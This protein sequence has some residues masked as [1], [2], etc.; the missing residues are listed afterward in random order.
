M[1]LRRGKGKRRE[2]SHERPIETKIETQTPLLTCRRRSNEA[3]WRQVRVVA[4]CIG[5]LRIEKQLEIG[6]DGWNKRQ[7]KM[8]ERKRSCLLLWLLF[9]SPFRIDVVV[10][11]VVAAAAKAATE[12]S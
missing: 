11:V 8:G 1:I 10:V 9:V 12:V 4:V 7:R 2:E 6:I 3:R 5:V